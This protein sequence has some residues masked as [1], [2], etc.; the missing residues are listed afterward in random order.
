M[1]QISTFRHCFPW[2][3]SQPPAVEDPGQ[4]R[5]SNWRVWTSNGC[6]KHSD[7]DRMAIVQGASLKMSRLGQEQGFESMWLVWLLT[8]VVARQP[9]SVWAKPVAGFMARCG[10]PD[11]SRNRFAVG[12]PRCFRRTPLGQTQSD[13]EPCCPNTQV[14]VPSRN[15]PFL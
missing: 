4:T 7:F 8:W 13:P 1:E 12:R 3:R 15:S 5:N 9:K 10:C 14:P 6:T 11:V 2:C